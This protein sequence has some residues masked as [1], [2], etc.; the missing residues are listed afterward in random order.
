MWV[1][2]RSGELG[3]LCASLNIVHHLRCRLVRGK[4]S[5]GTNNAQLRSAIVLL[6]ASGRTT[7]QATWSFRR[8]SP[9]LVTCP[10]HCLEVTSSLISCLVLLMLARAASDLPNVS[11]SAGEGVVP[12]Q[13]GHLQLWHSLTGSV[14]NPLC[15]FSLST[16][17]T[18]P[19]EFFCFCFF[20]PPSHGHFSRQLPEVGSHPHHST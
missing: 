10:T 3:S 2:K 18:F 7:E 19:Q 6:A 12:F 5:K 20:L 15:Y 4:A 17:N 16:N 1:V 11:H 8:T 13:R 9:V 14:Q